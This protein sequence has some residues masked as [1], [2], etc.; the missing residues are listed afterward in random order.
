MILSHDESKPRIDP[1]GY[2]AL[3]VTICGDVRISSGCRIML[4]ACVVAGGKA[5]PII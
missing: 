3:N 4:G 2:T 5:T 1:S